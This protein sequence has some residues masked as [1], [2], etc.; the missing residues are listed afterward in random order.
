MSQ[1]AVCAPLLGKL[2]DGARKIA[3]ELFQLGFKAGEKRKRVGCRAGKSSQNLVVIEPA[4]LAG[5]T[6]QNLAAVAYLAVSRHHDF[7]IATNANHRRGSYL[8]SHCVL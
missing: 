8:L 3:V 2:H 6:L 5:R 7:V 4:Q 1:R